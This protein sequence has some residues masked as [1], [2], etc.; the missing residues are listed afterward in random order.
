MKTITHIR[1]SK[2][3]SIS[4]FKKNPMDVIENSN[5]EAVAILNRNK[6]VF[7]C[8]PVELFEKMMKE[9]GHLEDL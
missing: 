7:Y 8:V 6:P 5:G 1:T 2:I 4:E 9:C 3:T